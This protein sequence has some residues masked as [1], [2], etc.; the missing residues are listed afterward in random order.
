MLNGRFTKHFQVTIRLTIFGK[1]RIVFY[2]NQNRPKKLIRTEPSMKPQK[3]VPT[4]ST[5][6]SN[7]NENQVTVSMFKSRKST[8]CY[9]LPVA[10]IALIANSF[11]CTLYQKSNNLG[12]TDTKQLPRPRNHCLP[13]PSPAHCFN[14]AETNPEFWQGGG[15]FCGNSLGNVKFVTSVSRKY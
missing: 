14:E 2:S 8:N 1:S 15:E 3:W 12:L 10:P 9:I 6:L 13:L 11:I 4:F 5:I 7:R